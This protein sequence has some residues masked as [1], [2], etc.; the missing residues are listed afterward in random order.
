MPR[1]S[2]IFEYVR[3]TSIARKL[4]EVLYTCSMGWG[5]SQEK[6]RVSH[7]TKST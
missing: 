7:D 1:M 2:E 4:G 3:L 5:I 6:F